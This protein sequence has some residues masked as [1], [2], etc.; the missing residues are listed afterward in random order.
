[1]VDLQDAQPPPPPNRGRAG[2]DASAHG[3]PAIDY[4]AQRARF[5]AVLDV[6]AE[7]PAVRLVLVDVGCGE[8]ELLAHLHHRGLDGRID[9]VGVDAS[10]D[11]LAQARAHFPQARFLHLDVD[12]AQADLGALGCDYLV[13]AHRFAL[14][15]AHAGDGAWAAMQATIARLWPHVRRGMAFNV[16]SRQAGVDDP[17]AFHAP[18]DDVAALLHGLAGPRV[19]IRADH[20][21]PEYT[22]FALRAAPVVAAQPTPGPQRL[23][24]MRPQLAGA[25]RLLPYL[26]RIDE[27]RVYSNFGPLAQEFE[28]RLATQLALPAGALVSASSGLAALVGAILGT[29]GRATAAKPL[30]L[31]PAYTFIATASAAELCG[32]EPSLD[33]VDATHWWLDPEQVLAHPQLDRIGVVIPV[34]PYGRPVPQAPWLEFRRRTGIPVVIDGAACFDT[35]LSHADGLGALPVALS[36]HATKS[37]GVGEGGAVACT[38]PD[39]L[40]RSAR[41][42]NFGFHSIRDCRSA[43][44]N[45]KL[46]EYHAAVGLAELDGWDAKLT[47]FRRVA[48]AYRADLDA[49]GLGAQLHAAPDIAANYVLFAAADLDQAQRACSRMETDGIEYR[50][51]YGLGLHRQTYHAGAPSRPL[52]VTDAI[53]PR[54]LGLPTAPDLSAQDVARVC[55]TLRN[56]AA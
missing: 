39:A 11:A 49:A 1:M 45:G 9:Y 8:G 35:L 43:N 3:A 36:F 7:A 53:A 2:N 6:L 54:L 12:D 34:A 4:A 44:T 52:P 20:G 25:E 16:A 29:V 30:A 41:A 15:R 42:L 32:F 31:V 33:D 23:P 22:A 13:A 10:A 40:E 19:R 21:L 47:S 55:A 38:D 51:W 18:M 50:Y 56:A 26:R 48:A 37:L 17:T 27:R 28:A 46:S 5:D 14:R 24:A